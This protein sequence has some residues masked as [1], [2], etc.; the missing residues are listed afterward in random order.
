MGEDTFQQDNDPKHSAKSTMEYFKRNK[1]VKLDW[2]P[3]SP[4]LNPI[5]HLWEHI[6][7]K[8]REESFS[9]IPGL[10]SRIEKVWNEISPDVTRNLVSS[11]TRRLEAIIKANGGPTKY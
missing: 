10:K 3:Q 1:I 5:E 7:R 11:M 2:P 8:V 9:G 6:E 4:D